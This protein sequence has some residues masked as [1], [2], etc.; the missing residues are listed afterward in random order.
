M[1]Q[2]LSI[3]SAPNSSVKAKIHQTILFRFHFCI[4]VAMIVMRLCRNLRRGVG[5]PGQESGHIRIG[6]P[7]TV[8]GLRVRQLEGP[9][10]QAVRFQNFCPQMVHPKPLSARSM[11]A[12]PPYS[13]LSESAALYFDKSN[14]SSLSPAPG[15]RTDDPPVFGPLFNSTFPAPPGWLRR[16]WRPRSPAGPPGARASFPAAGAR[17]RS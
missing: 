8:H 1:L 5:W 16:C 6:R 4:S 11:C 2:A 10:K 15:R 9:Q 14:L 12:A 7:V 17:C 3:A 13:A